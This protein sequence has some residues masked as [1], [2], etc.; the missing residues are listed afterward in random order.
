VAAA[1]PKTKPLFEPVIITVPRPRL[2]KDP[3]ENVVKSE[4]PLT[5]DP[6]KNADNPSS[7]GGKRARI[8][9]GKE[10]SSVVTPTCTISASQASLSILN[11]GGSL[12]VLV[13][14]EGEGSLKSITAS[15]DSPEDVEIRL[16]PEIAGVKGQA[17]YVIR[18]AT[19]KTGDFKVRFVTPCGSKEISVNVR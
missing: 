12:G 8:V 10:V 2:K 9:M 5:D 19:T 15:S 4:R 13:H 18:S 7:D 3:S 11:N 6:T 1:E 16:E 14:M 17:F